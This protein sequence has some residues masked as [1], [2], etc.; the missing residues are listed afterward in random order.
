[1][2]FEYGCRPL[3]A[4]VNPDDLDDEAFAEPCPKC[5]KSCIVRPDLEKRA[6]ASRFHDF[7]C[8]ICL[9]GWEGTAD[10]QKCDGSLHPDS[11]YSSCESRGKCPKIYL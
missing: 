2:K 9:K 4:N 7:C 8:Q 6:R 3:S 1:M 10:C 11:I 5:G